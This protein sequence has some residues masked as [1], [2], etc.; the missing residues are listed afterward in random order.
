MSSSPPELPSPPPGIPKS[1]LWASLA[2][3]P[4]VTVIGTLVAGS[5]MN[6]GSIGEEFLLVLTVA[7]LTI[8]F[9]LVSFFSACLASDVR[10]YWLA[11]GDPSNA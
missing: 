8:L 10:F 9:C 1:Q 7:L 6:S 4:V 11:Q 5:L 2:A 3:P